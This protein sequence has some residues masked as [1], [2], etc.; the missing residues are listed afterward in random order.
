MSFQ[1]WKIRLH[2]TEFAA[3]DAISFSPANQAGNYVL[4]KG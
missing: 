2:V 1:V 3:I 4:R